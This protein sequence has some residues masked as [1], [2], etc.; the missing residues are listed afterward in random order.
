VRNSRELAGEVFLLDDPLHY[1]VGQTG[2][3]DRFQQQPPLNEAS[4][5]GAFSGVVGRFS[6]TG[7]AWGVRRGPGQQGRP[8][9]DWNQHFALH[10][11]ERLSLQNIRINL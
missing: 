10:M 9:K 6:V 11:Y 4:G 1:T 2:G 5:L 3:W 7:A 8:D